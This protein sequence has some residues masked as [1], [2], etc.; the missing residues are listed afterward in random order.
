MLHKALIPIFAT[1]LLAGCG[2]RQAAVQAVDPAPVRASI[3]RVEARPFALTVA[4]TGTLVSNSQVEVKAETTG[5][6]VKFPKE[7]G[8][9]VSA[10]E[11]VVWVDDSNERILVRQAET[12]VQVADASLERAKVNRN[13]AGSEFER[14]RNLLKS[15]GITD[16][17]YKTAELAGRDAQSQVALA[18]AQLDQSRAHL[19]QARKMLNDSIVRSPVA[20]QI[21]R[22]VVN[23][24]AYVEP[25]TVVFSVVDN[26]RLELESMVPTGDLGA[27]SAGQRVTFTVNSFP[28]REFEGRVIEINPAVQAETRSAKV[29]I[30][31]NN[32]GASSRPECSRKATSSRASRARPS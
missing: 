14:A 3:V 8:D 7:E 17:D 27:I 6:I 20:G 13:H 22:K 1:A 2:K 15:G 9:A 18:E 30:R 21:Q 24:G 16:R 28:D 23:E 29:R 26:T 19:D 11:A 32:P 25:T 31:V 5:R 4:I 10:R 12:A